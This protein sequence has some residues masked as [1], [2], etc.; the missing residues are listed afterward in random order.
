MLERQQN[1]EYSRDS[2]CRFEMPDVG[3]NGAEP[4]CVDGGFLPT[5]FVQAA[6]RLLQAFHFDRVSK[7]RARSMCLDIGDRLRRDLRSPAGFH[8]QLRLSYRIGS[9]Q[10]L[11]LA[12]M[13]HGASGDEAVNGVA[14]RQRLAQRL[15]QEDAYTLAFHQAIGCRIEG[16]AA[17]VRREDAEL[18]RFHPRL[19]HEIEADRAGEGPLAFSTADG[20][21]GAMQ[22]DEAGRARGVDDLARPAQVE[23][24][25]DAVGQHGMRVSG[26]H[27]RG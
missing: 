6:E 18:A 22:R 5:L 15:Q 24:I 1:L 10:R 27:L 19:R 20:L 9:G 2:R 26:A 8:N 11:R 25:R 12:A 21:N 14:V 13:I 16:A 7:L 4:A 3:L 23:Q 17:A